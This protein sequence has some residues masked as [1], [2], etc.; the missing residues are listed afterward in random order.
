VSMRWSLGGPAI[1]AV[2]STNGSEEVE[3]VVVELED[4]A[5]DDAELELELDGVLVS[6]EVVKYCVVDGGGDQVEEGGTQVEVVDGAGGGE[7]GSLS[8]HQVP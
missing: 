5:D 6:G 4:E 8:N 3:E 1:T 2:G 7:P